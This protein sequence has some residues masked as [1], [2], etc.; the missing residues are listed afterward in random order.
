MRLAVAFLLLAGCSTLA[1]D[2]ERLEVEA[3]CAEMWRAHDE[4]VLDEVGPVT[5]QSLNRFFAVMDAVMGPPTCN[6]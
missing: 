6:H 2:P 1:E 5:A 3:I 4:I